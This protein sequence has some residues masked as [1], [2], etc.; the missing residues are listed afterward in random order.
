[1]DLVYTIGHS[2][3]TIEE[4]LE[5]LREKAVQT[6]A[7]VRRFPGSRRY[8]HFGK[9]QLPGWLT[10]AGIEY[11]HLDALGG[12]RVPR[13]DS[14]NG[15]WR[16]TQFRGYADHMAS[17]EFRTALEDLIA[18]GRTR[19]VAIMCAEAVPWRCHRQLIADA[20]L[21]RDV[22]VQ[23]ILISGRSADHELNPNARVLPGGHIVYPATGPQLGLL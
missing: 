21:A 1:M 18:R 16:N 3:R 15:A 10:H 5:L 7:D 6:V 22:H 12:R 4:F 13:D 23:H 14:V 9:D 20:L 11:V 19:Q 2:T 17:A 8:P